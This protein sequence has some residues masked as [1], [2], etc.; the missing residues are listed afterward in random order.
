MRT[1]PTKVEVD[2]VVIPIDTSF[3]TAL[4]CMEVVEDD[5]ISDQERALAIIFLLTDTIP[6]VDLIKLLKVLSKYLQCGQEK[7]ERHSAV[8]DMDL[9][10][11]YKYIIASFMHDYKIDLDSED[12]HWWRFMELLNGLSGEC[13]LN[14]VRDIRTMDLS[15]YKDAKTKERILKARRQVALKIKHTETEEERNHLA[16]FEEHFKENQTKARSNELDDD[17]YLLEDEE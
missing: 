7:I 6:E 17:D 2:G 3:K 12:M 14:R 8:K 15:I 13:I 11:D 10:Q 16:K 4:K 9:D 5:G 1:Y